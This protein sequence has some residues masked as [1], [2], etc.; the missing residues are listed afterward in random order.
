ME[1]VLTK[2]ELSRAQKYD[3]TEYITTLKANMK[4]VRDM[5]K[6][7]E[8][9]EKEMQKVYHDRKSVVREFSVGDYVLVF[10]PIRKGKL[11]NQWQGP[12]IITNKI[13]EVTY[14]VDWGRLGSGT[15]LS[16]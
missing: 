11:E 12:F 4:L 7:R 3:T 5:A 10:R 16:M 1:G 14:Q 2:D 15:E 9:K 13:T 8:I 6:E